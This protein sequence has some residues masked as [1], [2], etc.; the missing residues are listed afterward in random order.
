MASPSYESIRSAETSEDDFGREYNTNLGKRPNR[1]DNDEIIV[2]EP[3]V[4]K[5]KRETKQQ[6]PYTDVSPNSDEVLLTPI[7]SLDLYIK[8]WTI[9]V[10]VVK[11]CATRV[12]N[13]KS[14]KQGRV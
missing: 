9:K 10:K 4:V 12:F 11:M 2:L 13:C 3:P 14:G 5:V 7:S 8:D 1:I 6:V